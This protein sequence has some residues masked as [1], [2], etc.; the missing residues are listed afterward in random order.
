M[1]T[2][3]TTPDF[4]SS[5]TAMPDTRE[6]AR[7]IA[8]VWWLWLVTG[9]AWIIASLVIVQF[10]SA[11]IATIGIIV[12]SMFMF[13]A[14]QQFVIAAVT[15]RLRW[16]WI[17]FGLLFGACGLV[18]FFNP[19]ETFAGLADVL[20]FLFLT[21]GVFW[22]VRAFIDRGPVWWLGVLSG[23]LMVVMAFWTS[24]QFFIEKAY[25]LLVFAGIWALLHGVGDIVRAFT[26]RSLRDEL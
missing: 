7:A 10:N 2:P 21:V 4:G 14:V 18:A 11:S 24:G 23:I 5:A 3:A 9:V 20:G 19:A 8:G 22:I 15:D 17:I 25:M 26:V 6:A 1:S 13:S 12:G 16:L